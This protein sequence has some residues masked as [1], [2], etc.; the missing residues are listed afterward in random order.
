MT[1][2]R[3]VVV[4]T[5]FMVHPLVQMADVLLPVPAW[6]ERSGHYC[7]LEGDRRKMNVVVPPQGNLKG[8]GVIMKELAAKLGRTLQ[9]ASTA[10]CENV[11]VAKAAPDKAQIVT[12]KEVR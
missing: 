7:T 2:A 4:Q 3:F 1:R 11:Y 5:P 8:L 12:T 9:E 10:P 6:F